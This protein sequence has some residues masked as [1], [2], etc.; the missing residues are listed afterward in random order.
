[1][2]DYELETLKND[3]EKKRRSIT[4]EFQIVDLTFGNMYIFFYEH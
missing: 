3:K 2:S 4:R 1:M